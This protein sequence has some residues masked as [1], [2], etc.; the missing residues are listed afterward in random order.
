MCNQSGKILT[1]RFKNAS[2][3][4]YIYIKFP[5]KNITFILHLYYTNSSQHLH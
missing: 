5:L 1:D 4:I 2:I 3:Y